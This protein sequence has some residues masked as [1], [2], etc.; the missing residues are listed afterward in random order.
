MCNQKIN[1]LVLNQNIGCG[2]LELSVQRY[3]V[4]QKKGSV[5]AWS[6]FGL[7]KR[8]R[9]TERERERERERKREREREREYKKT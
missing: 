8:E 9:E 7:I 6:E 3:D 4:E 1:F 5:G 2:Y